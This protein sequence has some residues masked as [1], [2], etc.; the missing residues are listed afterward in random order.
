M[1]LYMRVTND[2]YELPVAVADTA[3]ELAIMTGTNL[4]VVYSSISKGR[5]TYKKVEVEDDDSSEYL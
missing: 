1:T 3:K 4:N 5:K 2:E